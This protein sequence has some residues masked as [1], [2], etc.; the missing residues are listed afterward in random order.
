MA[1]E[2]GGEAYIG[3]PPSLS[4][5]NPCVKIGK[6]RNMKW[7]YQT[8]AYYAEERDIGQ[9]LAELGLEGWEVCGVLPEYLP[10]PDRDAFVPVVLLKRPLPP[11]LDPDIRF[12]GKRISDLNPE[13]LEA[14]RLLGTGLL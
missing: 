9:Q 6:E 5:F 3:L 1:G 14:A 7:E 8:L 12:R 11:L 4:R 2:E 13:E 10:H